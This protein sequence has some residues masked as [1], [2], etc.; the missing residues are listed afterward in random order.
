[1]G[2]MSTNLKP[3]KTMFI[4]PNYSPGMPVKYLTLKEMKKMYPSVTKPLS[5]KQSNRFIKM[6]IKEA[7][8]MAEKND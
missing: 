1:M 4:D 2:F 7:M 5:F 3:G 6:Q 8:E